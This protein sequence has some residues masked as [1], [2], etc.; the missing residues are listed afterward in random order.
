MGDATSGGVVVRGVMLSADAG[1]CRQDMASDGRAG[2]AW[3]FAL[4][5]GRQDDRGQRGAFGRISSLGG[6]KLTGWG[7]AGKAL[8]DG[9]PISDR[10]IG[11]LCCT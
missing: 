11:N 9:G 1:T 2:R 10:H 3:S 8:A 4:L 6:Y 7:P 5:C